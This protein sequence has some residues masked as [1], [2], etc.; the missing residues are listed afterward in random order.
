MSSVDVP[1]LPLDKILKGQVVDSSSPL[2]PK[3]FGTT[4]ATPHQ[5]EPVEEYSWLRR[6]LMIG[7]AFWGELTISLVIT[8]WP[9]FLPVLVADGAYFDLCSEF[10]QFLRNVLLTNLAADVNTTI[11]F[12]INNIST[13][14]EQQVHLSY[15]STVALGVQNSCSPGTKST[16][17]NQ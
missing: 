13:C 2:L 9:A 17:C 1:L 5:V 8:G 12:G 14:E 16:S 6:V 7:W 4:N 10:L 15:M 3:R 11:P